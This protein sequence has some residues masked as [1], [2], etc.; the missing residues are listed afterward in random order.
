MKEPGTAA[1]YAMLERSKAAPAL[2]QT[3][4]GTE[5]EQ[6][7]SVYIV[8]VHAPTTATSTPQYSVG[9]NGATIQCRCVYRGCATHPVCIADTQSEARMICDA[10]NESDKLQ[11]ELTNIRRDRDKVWS[12]YLATV[13]DYDKL[14]RD[15]DGWQKE[16]RE[17]RSIALATVEE[18][19]DALRAANKSVLYALTEGLDTRGQYATDACIATLR[20]ALERSEP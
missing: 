16:A 19:R 18:E 9:S 12:D 10:L 8:P 4:L 15:R 6:P 13:A 5:A 14:Q 20:A 2:A 7:Q 1:Y 17:L 11:S 3:E